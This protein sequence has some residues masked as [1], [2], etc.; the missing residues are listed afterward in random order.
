MGFK[1]YH[2]KTHTNDKQ[3]MP[4][5]LKTYANTR[6]RWLV[7]VSAPGVALVR[8]PV[9]I[10]VSAPVNAPVCPVYSCEYSC[11]YSCALLWVLLVILL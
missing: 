4:P 2:F 8:S 6:N 10:P 9:R 7:L 11:D 3:V 5:R 1:E